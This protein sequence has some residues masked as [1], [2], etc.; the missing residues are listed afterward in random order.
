MKKNL[1]AILIEP[2]GQK[3]LQ[4]CMLLIAGKYIFQGKLRYLEAPK[5]THL[6]MKDVC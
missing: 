5:E 2:D 4:F 1:G 6:R 3:I